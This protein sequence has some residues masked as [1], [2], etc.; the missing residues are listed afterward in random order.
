MT[1]VSIVGTLGEVINDHLR[2][3][4]WERLIPGPTG[5]YQIDRIPA[6]SYTFMIDEFLKEKTGKTIILR[7]HL[8]SEEGLGAI[9]AIEEYDISSQIGSAATG[10]KQ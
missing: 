3:V 6:R 4:E 10:R 9:V 1:N 8:E 7:G 2:Y 5:I